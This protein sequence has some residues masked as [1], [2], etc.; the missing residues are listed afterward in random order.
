[1]TLIKI[2]RL[3]FVFLF[4]CQ[5]QHSLLIA[6]PP[7]KTRVSSPKTLV[8]KILSLK[9]QDKSLSNQEIAT[10]LNVLASTDANAG[11]AAITL[12][13]V[14]ADNQENLTSAIF[15]IIKALTTQDSSP[16]GTTPLDRATDGVKA[17]LATTNIPSK[18]GTNTLL[19]YAAFFDIVAPLIEE[20]IDA[21]TRA[22]SVVSALLGGLT[23][24]QILTAITA[25]DQWDSTPLHFAAFSQ[26]SSATVMTA[27]CENITQVQTK[28]LAISAKNIWGYTPIHHAAT[29]TNLAIIAPL[30]L[31]ITPIQ[32]F[33]VL[34]AID[35]WSTTPL[36]YAALFS[37]T[38]IIDPLFFTGITTAQLRE[39]TSIKNQW[40]STVVH[41]AAL[42]SDAAIIDPL[43][44]KMNPIQKIKAITAKNLWGLS[45]LELSGLAT[46]QDTSGSWV[47]SDSTN[48]LL[49]SITPTPLFEY[50]TITLPS[51]LGA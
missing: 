12:L 6:K 23:Q 3:L 19:H 11:Q 38:A 33:K 45:P 17:V 48:A 2:F 35:K 37:N 46:T 15:N 10:L 28:F 7:F 4:F 8:K 13:T 9:E 34:T 31:L 49:G 22:A 42:A 50:T 21:P 14:I 30:F 18:Y 24:S 16:Q 27:L 26:D 25:K 51:I 5:S 43:F 1:M 41:Y 47:R 20:T 36:H 29:S 44:T 39:A 32:K 40:D